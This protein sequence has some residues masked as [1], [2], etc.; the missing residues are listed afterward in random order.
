MVSYDKRERKGEVGICSA[1]VG[2]RVSKLLGGKDRE[3]SN[4]LFL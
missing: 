1:L 4:A 3:V 2:V